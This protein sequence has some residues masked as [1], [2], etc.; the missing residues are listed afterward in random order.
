[1]G[2]VQENS[3]TERLSYVLQCSAVITVFRFLPDRD[4]ADAEGADVG[5]RGDGDGDA[6]VA[7]R[8][9]D[10][11]RQREAR[12]VLVALGGNSTDF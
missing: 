11:L 3:K 1:M 6:G 9:P 8:A 7:H 10:L 5:E 2:P 4:S 12:L